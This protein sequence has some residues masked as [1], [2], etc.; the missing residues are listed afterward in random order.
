MF[1]TCTGALYAPQPTKKMAVMCYS[2]TEP[3]L[4]GGTGDAGIVPRRTISQDEIQGV[5]TY[6]QNRLVANYDLN[7]CGSSSMDPPEFWMFTPTANRW[8]GGG[9]V[10]LNDNA[11]YPYPEIKQ[12][13]RGADADADNDGMFEVEAR[14]RATDNQIQPRAV[15]FVRHVHSNGVVDH[16]Q[17]CDSGTLPLNQWHTVECGVTWDTDPLA[18]GSSS[19]LEFEYGVRVTERTE[20][21]YIYVVDR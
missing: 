14:V 7:N 1:G 11:T 9:I 19:V 17:R 5:V 12:R 20:I 10:A 13:V 18:L 8:C 16:E 3:A 21:T 2:T 4:E 6:T 15:I